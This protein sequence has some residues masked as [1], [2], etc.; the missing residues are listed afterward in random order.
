MSLSPEKYTTK[1]KGYEKY[2]RDPLQEVFEKWIDLR[3]G[4]C[5]AS[6]IQ[7]Y[8]YHLL[9]VIAFFDCRELSTYC[10]EDAVKLLNH[11]L[12]V[13]KLNPNV[14]R[15]MMRYFRFV[16]NY[17]LDEGVMPYMPINWRKLPRIAPAKID[18][19]PFTYEE[20]QTVKAELAKEKYS[21]YWGDACAVAWH[22]GL[23]C[24]DVALMKMQMV[25]LR[26]NT[27]RSQTMKKSR[28]REELEIPIEPELRPVLERLFLD[29][30]IYDCEYLNARM[31]WSYKNYRRALIG[32]FRD[33]CDA[34]GLVKH[35]FHS[36]RHGFV[37]RLLNA[38]VDSIIISSITGQTIE[39]I[40]EYSHV[41]LSA[42]AAAMA[43]SRGEG[44]MKVV[45]L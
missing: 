7:A 2:H 4:T 43:R 10:Q 39:Q 3:R 45:E 19:V 22:T 44:T 23:R 5:K 18:K 26:G 16:M 31:A 8:R 36:F 30:P 40:Q 33:A 24:G 6:S 41:S 11:L 21:K 14:V 42:K 25:D 29:R 9:H 32:E 28:E 37:T 15:H 12:N 13:K 38:G 17:A 1:I 20:Y 27:I 34:C 35:S